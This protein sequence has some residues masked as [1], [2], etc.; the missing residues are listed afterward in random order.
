MHLDLTDEEARPLARHL[1]DALDYSPVPVRPAAR[2]A[3]GDP[4]QARPAEA[5]A[6]NRCRRCQRTPASASGEV[7][8]GEEQ[9][10]H[11]RPKTQVDRPPEA[12]SDPPPRPRW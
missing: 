2:S 12:R 5:S 7:G 3:E 8:G 10:A 11:A 9:R 4:R 6:G 1:R